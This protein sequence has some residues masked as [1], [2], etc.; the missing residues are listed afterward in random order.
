MFSQKAGLL[1]GV[2]DAIFIC[3]RIL[4][5]RMC[6]SGGYTALRGLCTKSIPANSVH[7]LRTSNFRKQLTYATVYA[8]ISESIFSR[9]LISM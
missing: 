2:W 1:L 7:M 5:I 9:L 8:P 3:I 6:T 4:K